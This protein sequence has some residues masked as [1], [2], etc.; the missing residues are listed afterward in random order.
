VNGLLGH[1]RYESFV[2]LKSCDGISI[3][4]PDTPIGEMSR[5]LNS[6]G[7][8]MLFAMSGRQR[9]NTCF[10]EYS[11]AVAGIGLR[12]A[13][14]KSADSCSNCAPQAVIHRL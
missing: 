13:L 7:T 3:E 6:F 14:T 9:E 11:A 12:T 10:R 1:E 5:C 2:I 4:K 8:V